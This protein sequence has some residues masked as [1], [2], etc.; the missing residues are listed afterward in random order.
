M[1]VALVPMPAVLSVVRQRGALP[2][3]V[4]VAERQGI[5]I[6]NGHARSASHSKHI[7][8]QWQNGLITLSERKHQTNCRARTKCLS[9]IS[10]ANSQ[11]QKLRDTLRSMAV[12]GNCGNV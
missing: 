3:V 6:L 1:V 10:V 12:V 8:C 4:S 11:R 5:R 7:C 2:L 9:A